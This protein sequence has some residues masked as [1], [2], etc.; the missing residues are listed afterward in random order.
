MVG[1]VVGVVVGV[2]EVDGFGFTLSAG[3]M[4]ALASE[5]ATTTSTPGVVA[6]S[7]NSVAPSS[8]A[9]VGTGTQVG[10]PPTTRPAVLA[11]KVRS[12]AG[13][14]CHVVASFQFE[15]AVS[16]SNRV[17]ALRFGMKQS[18]A[19]IVERSAGSDGVGTAGFKAW[20]ACRVMARPDAAR[21]MRG[22]GAC[23]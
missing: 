7:R 18:W 10:A 20:R 4:A 15:G 2:G 21:R 6:R 22:S 12:S 17:A 5:E 13:R 19:S 8:S 9:H 1:E 14:V 16:T 23:G 11:I 3:A